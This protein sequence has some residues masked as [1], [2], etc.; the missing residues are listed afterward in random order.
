MVW[1]TGLQ[2]SCKSRRETSNFSLTKVS[3]FSHSFV[4][5][6]LRPHESQHARPPCPSQTP[7]VHPNPCPSSLGCHPAISSSV[8][9]FSSCLQSLPASESFLP[10]RPDYLGIPSL[11]VRS[12]GC[13]ALSGVYNLHSGGRI[14]WNYCSVVCGLPTHRV[15]DLILLCLCPSS[16]S[17]WLRLCIWTWDIFFWWVPVSSCQWLFSS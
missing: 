17:L 12:P 8:I 14:S 13:K 3:Q 9:P 5:D 16:V 10:S 1:D 7:G 4:S 11:F 15:W 6:F 2:S